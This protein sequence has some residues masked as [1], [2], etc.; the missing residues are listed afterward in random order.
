MFRAAAM[1]YRDL[2]SNRWGGT[3]KLDWQVIEQMVAQG[4]RLLAQSV[5][6]N[7]AS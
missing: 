2:T 4:Y 5:A 3:T 6:A 7:H 1:Q